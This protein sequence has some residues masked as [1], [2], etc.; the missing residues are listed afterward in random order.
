MTSLAAE[1]PSRIHGDLWSGN[2][3]WSGGRGWLIDPAA[4]G[5]H[6][7]T[8]LAMLD[9]FGDK[10]AARKA[11]AGRAKL[12][13]NLG[14]REFHVRRRTDGQ[15]GGDGH[16]FTAREI[17]TADESFLVVR[18]R[19]PKGIDFP[20]L[21]GMVHDSFMSRANCIVVPGGKMTLAM[22]LI[23]TPMILQLLDRKRR[24][25]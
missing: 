18:F 11:E 15:V 2:V 7:E 25:G 3:L 4:H 6:R 17:P 5:G 22:Q 9:L 19:D 12:L 14:V 10:V 16:P 13:D 8:D 24:A 1:P 20:W 23:F 21:L